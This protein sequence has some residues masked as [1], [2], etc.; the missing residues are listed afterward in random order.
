MSNTVI[1]DN[2]VTVIKQYVDILEKLEKCGYSSLKADDY[3]KLIDKVF[4]RLNQ[5][6]DKG[7]KDIPHFKYTAP[8]EHRYTISDDYRVWGLVHDKPTWIIPQTPEVPAMHWGKVVQNK[9]IA[10]HEE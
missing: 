2:S 9:T 7:K 4:Q 10:W 5:E 1:E 3:S 6:I 8:K